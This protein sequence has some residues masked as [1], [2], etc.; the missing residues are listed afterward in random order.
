[1]A[2]K[3]SCLWWEYENSKTLLAH[4][5]EL[6]SCLRHRTMLSLLST[7]RHGPQEAYKHLYWVLVTNRKN[8]HA[9][10]SQTTLVLRSFF[11]GLQMGPEHF[12]LEGS[13]KIGK[14]LRLCGVKM[15][16]VGYQYLSNMFVS[17]LR[18]I[19]IQRK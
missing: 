7:D 13:V 18:T 12:Y 9:T 5:C 10:Q 1:M 14:W 6:K 11:D 3:H 17:L 8:I 19:S 16:S 4:V 15:L 2:L